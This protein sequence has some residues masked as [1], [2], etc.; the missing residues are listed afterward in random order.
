MPHPQSYR[1]VVSQQTYTNNNNNEN[2]STT[3]CNPIPTYNEIY[4]TQ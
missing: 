4:E 1:Q 3:I 2:A